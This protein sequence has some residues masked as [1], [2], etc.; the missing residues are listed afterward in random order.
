MAGA[1]EPPLCPGHGCPAPLG[2]RS[3]KAGV[4]DDVKRNAHACL[5]HIHHIL[6]PGHPAC[7]HI[8]QLA[9]HL[10]QAG[11]SRWRVACGG[12][13]SGAMPSP[14]SVAACCA[15]WMGQASSRQQPRT[16]SVMGNALRMLAGLHD[17][18]GA[19]TEA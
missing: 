6:P 12:W 11:R 1:D 3:P 13:W 5:I 8:A 16:L 18:V 14:A 19:Q 17:T 9:G 2:R 15:K 10:R 4:A 7:Q